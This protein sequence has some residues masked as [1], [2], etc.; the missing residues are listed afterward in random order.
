[1]RSRARPGRAVRR[2]ARPGFEYLSQEKGAG[3]ACFPG[4]AAR[5]RG[6][7]RAGAGE[8]RE[9]FRKQ[10][11]TMRAP[12]EKAGARVVR[13]QALTV[14]ACESVPVCT[15]FRLAQNQKFSR[16]RAWQQGRTPPGVWCA[17][18]HAGGGNR[19][20]GA[21]NPEIGCGALTDVKSGTLNAPGRKCRAP[22]DN[23]A[24]VWTVATVCRPQFCPRFCPRLASA[25]ARCSLA[26]GG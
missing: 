14:P 2:V 7:M 21:E 26:T 19:P 12:T 3:C 13:R 8:S 16:Q 20:R 5:R 17:G 22:G 6:W 11:G 25:V 23:A 10:S 9:A 4:V 18:E 15:P 1:M 24:R